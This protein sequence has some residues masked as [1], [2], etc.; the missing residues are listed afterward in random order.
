MIKST[1]DIQP[2]ANSIAE[3]FARLESVEAILLSGSSST[4]R[5]DKL[6]DLDL[7]VYVS[8]TIEN[9]KRKQIASNFTTEFTLQNKF[10]ED[11]DYWEVKRPPM[12][13]EIIYRNFSWLDTELEDVLI[14]HQAKVGYTTCFWTNLLNSKILYDK[15]GAAASLKEKY[16]FPYPQKLKQAIIEKNYPILK[17]SSASYYEQLKKAQVRKDLVS[18]NH[19]IAA[20]LAS[21]FDILFALN[22][23]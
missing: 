18:I 9:S 22:E 4:V 1:A 19:R 6:S 10:W 3:T 2:L 15:S 23:I 5:H 11:E 20:F 14:K 16:T 13:V 8:Q 21:Y 7:Y 12:L 17:T